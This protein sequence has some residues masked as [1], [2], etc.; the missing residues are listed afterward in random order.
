[1][2][3]S[4]AITRVLVATAML[5]SL[6]GCV[7]TTYYDDAPRQ[8]TRF[9]SQQAATTFYNAVLAEHY[10]PPPLRDD[11]K[12]AHETLSLWVGENFVTWNHVKSSNVIFND[13]A[14]QADTNHDGLITE[15]EA[16]AFANAVQAK[17]SAHPKTPPA[18]SSPPKAPTASNPPKPSP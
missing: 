7:H 5:C 17:F 8:D 1:M 10:P 6:S 3:K 13:A 18:C 12:P 9:E 2:I 16:A 4:F 14:A 11:D 15:A